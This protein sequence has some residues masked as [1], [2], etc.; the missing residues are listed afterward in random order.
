MKM[1]FNDFDRIAI[2]YDGLARLV[3]GSSIKL[4]QVCFLMDVPPQSKV[5]I[6]GGGTGWFLAEL[7]KLN[8]TC[9]V[10]YVEASEKMLELSKEKTNHSSRVHFIRGTENSIPAKIKFDVVITNFY[11][12]LFTNTSLDSVLIKIQG[13]VKP[14]TLWLVTDFT[15]GN[16]WWQSILLKT[17]YRFFQKTCNV[18]ASQ[19]TD[20]NQQL[21]KINLVKKKSKLFFGEFIEAAAYDCWNA[22]F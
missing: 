21:T 4:A 5:L 2:V 6:V 16:K 12:D 20:W 7:L 10:W 13:V 14:G 15:D 22:T 9:E 17:M 8:P 3:F 1:K 19:L 18:E 11:F